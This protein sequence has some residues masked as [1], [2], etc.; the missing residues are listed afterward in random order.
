LVSGSWCRAVGVGQLVS[1]SWCRA[2]GVGQLVSGSWCRAVGVGHLIR[3]GY[4]LAN[5][6][7]RIG[8]ETNREDKNKSHN[9]SPDSRDDLRDFFNPCIALEPLRQ[10]TASPERVTAVTSCRFAFRFRS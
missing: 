1:G 6:R 9:G 2:V 4:G 7:S 5:L 10:W 3:R 8:R